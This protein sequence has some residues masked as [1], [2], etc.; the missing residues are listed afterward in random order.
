[1]LNLLR[2]FYGEIAIFS[3]AKAWNMLSVASKL[4]P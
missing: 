2:V 1:M 4:D 3:E